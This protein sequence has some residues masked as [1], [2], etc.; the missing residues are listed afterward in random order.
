MRGMSSSRVK[1]SRTLTHSAEFK[2]LATHE[3]IIQYVKATKLF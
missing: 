3:R 2:S 1:L